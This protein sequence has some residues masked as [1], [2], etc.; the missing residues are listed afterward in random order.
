MKALVT[1]GSG[2]MGGGLF[3]DDI[4][5]RTVAGAVIEAGTA[6]Y[7]GGVY[8]NGAA[9][10]DTWTHVVLADAFGNRRLPRWA[11]EGI[12]VQ[13]EPAQKREL[14]WND[15]RPA[16]QVGE[17]IPLEQL[18]RFEDYPS[19]RLPL[20]YGQSASLVQF[21][22]DL[23]GEKRLVEVLKQS[24]TDGYIAALRRCYQMAGYDELEERWREHARRQI[25]GVRVA[26]N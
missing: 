20:F 24:Q 19:G 6:N 16:V 10:P 13:S 2:G 12:A 21:L 18:F 3:L 11:D 5:A 26:M 14:R 8:V 17:H 9:T 25:A 7:G 15:L 22:L 23:G 1:E 4:A